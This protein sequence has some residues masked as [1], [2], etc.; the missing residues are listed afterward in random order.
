MT[1]F[2]KAY[3][4]FYFQKTKHIDNTANTKSKHEEQ[5]SIKHVIN[6]RKTESYAAQE[7]K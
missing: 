1:M 4:W 2:K 6:L 3:V 5:I 7:I